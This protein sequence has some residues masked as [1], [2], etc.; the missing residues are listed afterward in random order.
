MN[1]LSFRSNSINNQYCQA[2]SDC[3]AQINIS[4]S[5]KRNRDTME[6][7]YQCLS[8]N[9]TTHEEAGHQ[10][11]RKIHNSRIMDASFPSSSMELS[12]FRRQLAKSFPFPS[13][14]ASSGEQNVDD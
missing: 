9:N 7:E 3:G 14:S 4:P 11:R 2:S 1:S 8:M 5:R 12:A 13:T 10:K 6:N